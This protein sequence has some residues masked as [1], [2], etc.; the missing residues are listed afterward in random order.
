MYHL[1]GDTFVAGIFVLIVMGSLNLFI[2]KFQMKYQK[3]YMKAKDLR[4]RKTNE[5]FS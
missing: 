4:L 1:I 3:K 5:I 2:G